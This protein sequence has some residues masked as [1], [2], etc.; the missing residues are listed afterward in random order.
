MRRPLPPELVEL[1]DHLELAARR[2]IGRRPTRRQQFFN[3]AT[4]LL[5]ALPLI[6]AVVVP[7]APPATPAPAVQ[8][9]ERGFAGAKADDFP[10]RALRGPDNP[11][12]AALAEPSTLRRALR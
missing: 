7:P 6:P 3:A 12:E 10:P 8:Q 5:V 9:S 1:G 4:G 2:S 11:G